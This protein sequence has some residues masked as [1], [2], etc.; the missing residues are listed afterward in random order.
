[1]IPRE[2][3]EESLLHFLAPVRRHLEDPTVSEI[4]INGP[5]QVFIERKGMLQKT[6]D[7]FP[8]SESLVSALRN[9]AQFVGKH[10][11]EDY[12]IVEAHLPDGSRL[13]GVLPP[14]ASSGPYLCIRR[15]F[16]TSL[17][18]ER[19]IAS[20]TVSEE[21]AEALAAMVAG[22]CNILVSG[23]TGTGKTS[24]LNWLTSYVPR[25]ERVGVIE[26]TKEV[27]VLHEHVFQMTSRPANQDGRGAVTIRDLFR[28]S[29]RMR[30]DRIIVGE[31]RGG[32]AIDIVQAMVSGHGGCLATLHASH[33]RDSLT[34][35][36]TMALTS[37]VEIPLTALR[38]QIA[39]G[40]DAI[41][42]VSRR[43]DGQR[44][45]THISEVLGYNMAESRYEVQD[46]FHRVYESAEDGGRLV[47]TGITPRFAEHM[48]EHGATWPLQELTNV[49]GKPS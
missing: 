47:S 48:E 13:Q 30:P 9:A 1:M 31:I 40:V 41:V 29:L 44:V 17:T 11:D 39:S 25:G 18:R 33:P 23:G 27:Q 14:L 42:Q 12:P 24:M 28:A 36:E 34:R 35:L 22:K 26:D 46:L 32:E 45:I 10:I 2:V 21:A 37:D 6:D 3:F 38:L 7:R 20:G 8:T 4:M 16:Q 19:L 15:F 43:R 5:D 49:K